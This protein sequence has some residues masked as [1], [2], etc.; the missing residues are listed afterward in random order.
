MIDPFTE[1]VQIQGRFRNK[2]DGDRRYNSLTFITNTDDKLEVKS[3][4]EVE[5]EITTKLESY[6]T[7]KE[8]Y[9]NSVD[10]ITRKVLQKELTKLSFNEFLNDEGELTE[11]SIDHAFNEE[12]VK[13]YYQS[14]QTLVNA[15]NET[16]HFRLRVI[17]N[18]QG[19]RG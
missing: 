10:E 16:G 8:K 17:D 19:W 1:A 18:S 12:R 5:T 9:D 15:Y 4:K 7:I 3:D 11:E 6:A 14:P 2:L 13:G